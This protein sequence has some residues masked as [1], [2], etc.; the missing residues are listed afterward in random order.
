MILL[1]I[2]C[3]QMTAFIPGKLQRAA[4]G[5][6]GTALIVRRCSTTAVPQRNGCRDGRRRLRKNDDV[7]DSGMRLTSSMY[8]N[9]LSS[10]TLSSALLL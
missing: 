2:A 9:G 6:L 8:V 5:A 1:H 4:Q 10:D 7:A 3:S